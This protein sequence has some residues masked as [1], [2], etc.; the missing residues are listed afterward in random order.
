MALTPR[1]WRVWWVR[2][3]PARLVYLM[4]IH[5][6]FKWIAKQE[7]CELFGAT[8]WNDRRAIWVG[9]GEPTLR[10]KTSPEGIRKHERGD[11]SPGELSPYQVARI[12]ALVLSRLDGRVELSEMCEAAGVR[13]RTYL[14]RGF[15][16][17]VGVT[18]HQWQISRRMIVAK[19][20]LTKTQIPIGEI[21]L[22]C[23][24]QRYQTFAR[25]FRHQV[26]VSAGEWRKGIRGR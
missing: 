5:A 6:H 3:S 10:W 7:A 9:E 14:V 12:K 18:P 25:A 26:G 21:A 11:R 19:S 17:A 13:S 16:L 4:T 24:Y 22:A 1:R 2:T 20:L 8:T 23:G 15:H